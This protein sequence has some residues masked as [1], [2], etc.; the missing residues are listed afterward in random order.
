M[1]ILPKQLTSAFAA[2][3]EVLTSDSAAA[4]QACAQSLIV[5]SKQQRASY[6]LRAWKAGNL[7]RLRSGVISSPFLGGL[8]TA[9]WTSSLAD[10]PAN[11]LAVPESEP[12]K[13]IPGTSGLGSQ[14]ELLPCSPDSVSSRT[15]KGT[16]RWDSPQ[17]SVIWKSW[18]TERRGDYSRRAKLVRHTS[19]SG[20]LSWPTAAA[21]DW[22]DTPGMARESTDKDGSPRSRT[23]QLARAVYAHGLAAPANL[24]ANGSRCGLLNPD[25]VETL[26]GLPVG[27]TDSACL[28]TESC[29]QLPK[30]HF[31]F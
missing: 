24:S 8:F 1:W 2:D 11:H 16:F 29:Q 5:R 3:T 14:M 17:S 28:A 9:K 10:I 30:E 4:S 13:M 22:K 23:D 20:C 25:W 7:T 21:R 6:F 18:V 27:W 31:K 12:E 15:S 19:G 26:M